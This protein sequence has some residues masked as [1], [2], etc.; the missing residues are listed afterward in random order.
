ML[1]TW[2]ISFILGYF[3]NQ[4]T[5]VILTITLEA[6]EICQTECELKGNALVE[7]LTKPSLNYP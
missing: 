2:M 4:E 5:N 1:F 7:I 3:L 6:I